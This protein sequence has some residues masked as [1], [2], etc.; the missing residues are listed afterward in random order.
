MSLR[1]DF[2]AA[3]GPTCVP[4]GRGEASRG[5]AIGCR[6][7]RVMRS[8]CTPAEPSRS[9]RFDSGWPHCDMTAPGARMPGC[10][11]RREASEQR[12]IPIDAAARVRGGVTEPE[13]PAVA[14]GRAL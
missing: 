2:H 8:A 7:L 13:D 10:S 5:G 1:R 9:I 4:S 14:G 12:T 6:P 3:P 11:Q